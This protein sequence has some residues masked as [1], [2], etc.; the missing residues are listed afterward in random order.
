[1]KEVSRVYKGIPVTDS[2]KNYLTATS[3][4]ICQL[5]FFLDISDIAQTIEKEFYSDKEWHFKYDV[6]AMIKFAIVKFFR[7]NP[8]R[9]YFC[10]KMKHGYLVFKIKKV[11][12]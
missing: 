8:I 3:V 9:K 11:T 12:Q 5:L 6:A 4:S 7:Q 10:H 1:M 2:L